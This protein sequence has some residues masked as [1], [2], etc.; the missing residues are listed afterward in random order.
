MKVSRT[1]LH[2]QSLRRIPVLARLRN[3]TEPVNLLKN[4]PYQ[5]SEFKKRSVHLAE[6]HIAWYWFR[7]P[8]CPTGL[9]HL[10]IVLKLRTAASTALCCHASTRTS[11]PL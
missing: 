10:D 1:P 9:P 6:T 2:E 4:R 11:C 3:L 8:I 7:R 5:A